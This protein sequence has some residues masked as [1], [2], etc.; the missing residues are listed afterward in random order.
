MNR[1]EFTKPT[2]RLALKRAAGRCE[3][4]GSMFGLDPGQRCCIPL[5]NGVRFEHVNPDANSKDNSIENCAAVCIRCWRY[6]TDHYDK[7]LVAKTLRQQDK[8]N[9]IRN[10]R[11]FRKPP[12]GYKYSWRT[13][14][15]EKTG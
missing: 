1:A 11:G 6:K 4:S 5:A 15:M 9:G 7:P 12:D 13:G 2:R 10:S 3:A 8:D 14:R